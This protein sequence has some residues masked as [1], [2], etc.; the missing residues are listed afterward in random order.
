M[1]L[2]PTSRLLY[3]SSILSVN[4]GSDY[5]YGYYQLYDAINFVLDVQF[6]FRPYIFER[7]GNIV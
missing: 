7:G 3:V 6:M 1:I 5:V 2:L 4:Y